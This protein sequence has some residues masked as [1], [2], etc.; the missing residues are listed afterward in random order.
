MNEFERR[1]I[2]VA[3]R[4][5]DLSALVKR[6]GGSPL[7]EHFGYTVQ[8]GGPYVPLL[9]GVTQSKILAMQSDAWF[10]LQYVSS[11]V[12]RPDQPWYFQ[13]S[14]NIK[15]QITD[16]GAGNILYSTPSTAGVLTATISR[17]QTGTPFLLPIPRLIAPNTNIKID[18]TQLG[19]N[20]TDNLEPIG[21]WLSLMGSRVTQ[22]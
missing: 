9:N 5:V 3:K 15:L 18:A 7:V 6:L 20:I 17:P 21:F 14:G 10:V 8:I 13:D 12:V 4:H 2:E 19:V 22:G 1:Q 11:C 16:T